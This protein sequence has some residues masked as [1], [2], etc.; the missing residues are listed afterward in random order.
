MSEITLP[1]H[2]NNV[3]GLELMR[4]WVPRGGYVIN[5]HNQ[6]LDFRTT[7]G[8]DGTDGTTVSGEDRRDR[9]DRWGDRV[10]FPGHG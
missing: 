1:L 8:T 5:D 10:R 3:V 2:I 7:G 9:R 6:W 4:A